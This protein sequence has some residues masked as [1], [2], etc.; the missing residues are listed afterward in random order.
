MPMQLIEGEAAVVRRSPLANH[1]VNVYSTFVQR[2][3]GQSA[4]LDEGLVALQW[5]SLSSL[6]CVLG[7][8]VPPP[9]LLQGPRLGVSMF[10]SVLL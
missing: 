6:A 1:R 5:L 8:P 2:H 3:G 4:C 7:H 10:E 9:P